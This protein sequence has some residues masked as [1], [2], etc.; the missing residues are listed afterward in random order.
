MDLSQGVNNDLQKAIDDITSVGVTGDAQEGS[1]PVAAP[2]SVP[3]GD[4]GELGDPIGPFP[5]AN[6]DAAAPASEPLAPLDPISVPELGT[7]ANVAFSP[8]LPPEPEAQPAAEQSAMA[9][10]PQQT[11]PE[12]PTDGT[13][14]EQPAPEASTLEAPAE[15]NATPQIEPSSSEHTLMQEPAQEPAA[16]DA[17]ANSDIGSSMDAQHVKEAAMRDLVPLLDRIDMD[18]AQKFR[19]CR[20]IFESI[21]DYAALDQAYRAAS[22]ITDE[23]ERAKS[24]LYIVEA[25][26]KK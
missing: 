11:T 5:E 9:E 12:M 2:S 7:S 22:A 14:A 6:A 25:V 4:N 15:D 13:P 19:V 8:V 1:S 3:E 16:N 23:N 18:A 24:L 21:H 26:D 10:T 20:D 17:S